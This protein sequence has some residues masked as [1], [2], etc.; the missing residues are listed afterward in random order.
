MSGSNNCDCL[1]FPFVLVPFPSG[2]ILFWDSSLRIPSCDMCTLIR[3][4]PPNSSIPPVQHIMDND[5]LSIHSSTLGSYLSGSE[6]VPVT[7]SAPV[8]TTDDVVIVVNATDNEEEENHAAVPVDGFQQLA[9]D[10]DD[11]ADFHGEVSPK[12]GYR[13]DSSGEEECLQ[14]RVSLSAVDTLFPFISIFLK[15]MVS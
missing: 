15:V 5:L 9:L 11:A 6:G 10:M 12:R 13:T 3:C 8:A 1:F 14:K 2:P 4:L 7:A